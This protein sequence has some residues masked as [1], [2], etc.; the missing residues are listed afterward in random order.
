[1]LRKHH[2]EVPLDVALFEEPKGD[3]FERAVRSE[4]VADG[5][6]RVLRQ[7]HIGRPVRRQHEQPHLVEA[8]GQIVQ[9]VDR[10]HV[11]PVE[12]VEKQDERTQPRGL[13]QQRAELALHA[14]L[15]HR[16]CV[17][18][19]AREGVLARGHM[20]DLH[21]PGGRDGLDQRM[22]RAPRRL[23]QQV[24]ECLE[25]RQI[26]L[27]TGKPLRTAAADHERTFRLLSDFRQKIL[28]EVGLTDSRLA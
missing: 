2:G 10:G 22:H 24:I 26:R 18:A 14:L 8:A 5:E 4:L 13:L 7:R 11:R 28:D 20:R 1:M 19:H 16:R 9:H 21:V 12:I 6:K 23:V 27:R 17:L 25:N 15:R 3:L